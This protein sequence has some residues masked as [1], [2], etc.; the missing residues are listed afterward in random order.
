[1]LWL[2]RGLR[3][4]SYMISYALFTNS[5]NAKDITNNSKINKRIKYINVTYYN[6]RENLLLE[7]FFLF[8]IVSS[9]NS[10][11]LLIKS[12]KKTLYNRYIRLLTNG[13]KKKC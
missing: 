12:L 5:T 8:R 1:M 4:L 6:I 3:E 2:K 9:N 11:D 10:T 13:S 7:E